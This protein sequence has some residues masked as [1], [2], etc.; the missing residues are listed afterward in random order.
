MNRSCL[1]LG[2]W[3]L[4]ALPL[5]LW[6]A[7]AR[8]FFPDQPRGLGEH[9]TA[10]KF[11]YVAEGF[12]N[13]DGGRERGAVYDGYLKLGFG[14][15]LEK[16]LGWDNTFFYANVL[17]PQG[18]SLSQKY[19]GDLNSVSN[20]DAYDSLRL[21]KCWVQRNFA[22]DRASLRLGII[23]V[24]KD[25]FAS[26]GAGLFLNSAFGAFSV[27]A[28]DTVAPVYPVSAPGVRVVVKPTDALA[29]RA[30]LFSGDVGTP[31]NNPRNLR[32]DFRGTDGL[33]GFLEGAWSRV[34]AGG[35]RG[36]Y[37]LGGFYNSKSVADLR[38]GKSHDGNYGVY[39]IADQQ[40]WREEAVDGLLEAR[41]QFLRPVRLR[42]SDRSQPGRLRY[43]R[44][45]STTPVSF[46]AGTMISSG[47]ASSIPA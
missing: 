28:Q 35:L 25:F 26:E 7:D 47:S 9:F 5:S 18:E 40:L 1:R 2:L 32:L 41:A 22:D 38:T 12:A 13:L 44:R 21:F 23:A 37:K 4:A 36:N 31:T 20:I 39:A 3:L 42:A 33:D 43:R 14:V 8:E 6:G 19:V 27:V 34:S 46:P 17:Y 15:N 45:D 30:A 10:W 29:L 16:L 11:N 24:D